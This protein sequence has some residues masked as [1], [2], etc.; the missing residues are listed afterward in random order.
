MTK[1]NILHDTF[2]E[3]TELGQSTAKKTVDSITG[4]VNPFD[5]KT[6]AV[7]ERSGK[8]AEVNKNKNHTPVDFKNLQKKF[9]NKDKLQAEALKNRLFQLVKREDEK[10]LDREKMEKQE[11]I[12]NEEYAL[13]EKK[14]REQQQKQSQMQDGMPTG[15]AKRGTMSRKKVSEQQHVENKPASGKQ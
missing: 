1:G 8:T 15:K 11:K 13:Q 12:R 5:S 14:R 3:L 2:E 9:E 6:S 4:I 7:E 10:S